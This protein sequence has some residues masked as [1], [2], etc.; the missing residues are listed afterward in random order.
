MTGETRHR[1]WG[2][3]SGCFW[4]VIS[5]VGILIALVV[6]FARIGME[7]DRKKAEEQYIARFREAT[8]N[9]RIWGLETH[10][11]YDDFMGN[12]NAT[13]VFFQCDDATM[14]AFL[15]RWKFQRDGERRGVIGLQG[16]SDKEQADLAGGRY[17]TL[18]NKNLPR[19]AQGGYR[20]AE[21]VWDSKTHTGYLYEYFPSMAV[22]D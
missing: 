18:L 16:L 1:L 11:F 3:F 5:S 9:A 22:L 4:G 8:P 14:N 13:I 7:S 21:L 17:R 15:K 10:N 20:E 12:R 19:Y 2:Y 6:V